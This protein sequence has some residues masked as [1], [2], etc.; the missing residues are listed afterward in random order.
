MSIQES[1]SPAIKS[2]RPA[3]MYRFYSIDVGNRIALAEDHKVDDD[4]N[5]L[6]L[7]KR[8]LLASGHPR[9]EVWLGNLRVG[10]LTKD[11][12]S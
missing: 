4:R 1:F 11:F 12:V 8:I 2:D 7:G 10:V 3:L 9:I 5:A 6:A